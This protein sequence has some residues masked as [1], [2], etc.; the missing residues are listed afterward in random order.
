MAEG[1]GIRLR[2]R[3]LACVVITRAG[4]LR[5]KDGGVAAA[6]GVACESAYL[7][8]TRSL[9]R[10]GAHAILSRALTQT[11]ADYPA[12]EP[13]QFER[14]A[15]FA[16]NGM[17]EVMQAHGTSA[18]SEGL[19]SLLASAFVLLERLVGPDMVLQLMDRSSSLDTLEDEDAP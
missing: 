13:L 14:Q 2:A 9:G 15:D 10:T 19:E 4:G 6:A 18:V 17:T 12:L 8:L 7:Q 3:A 16:L 5:S 1:G 11:Q